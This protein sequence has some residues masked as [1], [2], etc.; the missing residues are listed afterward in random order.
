[1]T[2]GSVHPSLIPPAPTIS[3]L[4]L[5][6][7]AAWCLWQDPRRGRGGEGGARA[8]REPHHPFTHQSPV[9]KALGASQASA[10]VAAQGQ[11]RVR[12]GL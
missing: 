2:L 4:S 8:D 12:V 7:Q 10:L 3:L 5:T 11:V 9:Q 6:R 1:M